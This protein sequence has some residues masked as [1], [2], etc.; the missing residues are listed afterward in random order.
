MRVL[1]VFALA[2]A[3][4]AA[5]PA[6]AQE[7]NPA[8]TVLEQAAEAMGGLDKLRSL[9]NVVYTGFGQRLYYQGGGNLTGDANSPP[10]WQAVTDVQRTFDLPGERAVYQERWAQEFPFAGFFG[11]NFARSTAPQSGDALL[12]FAD[13]AED[14]ALLRHARHVAPRLLQSH[15]QAAR[16]HVRRWLGAGADY[17]KA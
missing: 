12:R 10:K 5:V 7:A 14:S 9:D 16:A 3:L 13:L 6:S 4:F 1:G 17:L 2:C 8:R 11:L 15:V